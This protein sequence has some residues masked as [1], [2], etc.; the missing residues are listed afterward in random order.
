MKTLR[1]L[2]VLCLCAGWPGVSA[3]AQTVPPK[4]LAGEWAGTIAGQLP[5]VLHLRTNSA[6]ALTAVLDSP[7]QNAN[8]L[9][10]TD[11][12][13]AG[14]ILS[15]SVPIV[16]GSYSGTVSAD[17]QSISGTWTQ[18]QSMPLEFRQTKSGAQV[19]AEEA[20]VKPSPVD[21]NWAGA[22]S[23]GGSTLRIVFH[24]RSIPGGTIRCSMDSLDQNAMGIPCGEVAL[25]ANHVTLNAV[26]IHGTYD[27]TLQPD[28]R[29]IDGTW[30]QGTPLPLKLTKQ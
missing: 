1:V 5:L 6:G 4:A 24:F 2:L 15:F 20:A 29:H 3:P 21:G 23:A 10:G 22:L 25:D 17:G 13:L 26:A 19:A 9:A 8:G 12:R 7:S 11:V 27:G 18:A 28:R 30:S 14:N 16:H